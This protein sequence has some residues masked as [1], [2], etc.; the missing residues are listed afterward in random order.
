M[1]F[2][3]LI[4]FSFSIPF[5][6]FF[7]FL[8]LF[9]P[10]RL[11]LF[12]EVHAFV[13]HR[14]CHPRFSRLPSLCSHV[15]LQSTS[16]GYRL[17]LLERSDLA[18]T[19]L[20]SMAVLDKQPDVRLQL[21]QTLQI[22]SCASGPQ[23]WSIL[24]S[25]GEGGGRRSQSVES[26]PPSG[27][28]SLW[29]EVAA[30]KIT[31][32]LPFQT[33]ETS[34]H[35]RDLSVLELRPNEA[36]LLWVVYLLLM[37]CGFTVNTSGLSLLALSH[38]QQIGTVHWCSM[39]EGRRWFA[40][41]WTRSIRP[42][43]CCCSRLRCCGTCWR[44]AAG[45]RWRPSWAAWSASCRA[46]YSPSQLWIQIQNWLFFFFVQTDSGGPLLSTQITERSVY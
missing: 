30:L 42:A 14:T 5:S 46:H 16:P 37:Q 17:Q 6:F 18:Q 11:H 12:L 29:Y 22:L 25:S 33:V 38:D 8:S 21:L 1:A 39:R 24:G 20:L 26:T 34:N 15:G 35:Q 40:S 9:F 36:V 41:T 3:F 19:L 28:T 45:T 31:N 13:S 44:E 2:S 7:G 27:A 4:Y 32:P 23:A 43:R 10:Q